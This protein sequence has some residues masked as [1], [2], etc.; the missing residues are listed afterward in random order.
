MARA[1]VAR[2]RWPVSLPEANAAF[3]QPRIQAESRPYTELGLSRGENFSSLLGVW[4][5]GK[6][7]VR[8]IVDQIQVK[9]V[10]VPTLR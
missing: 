4:H 2:C 10:Q 5:R 7:S 9:G 6:Q 3:V 8:E 1:P